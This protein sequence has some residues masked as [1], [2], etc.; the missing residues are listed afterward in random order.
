MTRRVFRRFAGAVVAALLGAVAIPA[1]PASAERRPRPST[2]QNFGSGLCIRIEGPTDGPTAYQGSCA[3]AQ[4]FGILADTTIFDPTGKTYKITNGGFCLAVH[5]L[6]RKWVGEAS[7]ADTYAS[8]RFVNPGY[9]NDTVIGQLLNRH[10]MI[11]NVAT[12]DCLTPA[13]HLLTDGTYSTNPGCVSSSP[14][15]ATGLCVSARHQPGPT[16]GPIPRSTLL[17]HPADTQ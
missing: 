5:P 16:P 8:W 1:A 4:R 13:Q 12:G 2:F 15:P 17:R 9:S 3:W 14:T 7:C 6:T 10:N 11:Q